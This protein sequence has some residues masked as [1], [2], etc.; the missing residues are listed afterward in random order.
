M[1]RDIFLL[2]WIFHGNFAKHF[3]FSPKRKLK[4][5][6]NNSSQQWKND[7]AK[8]IHKISRHQF[9]WWYFNVDKATENSVNLTS[10][11]IC[12]DV[13]GILRKVFFYLVVSFF[14]CFSNRFLDSTLNFE[15]EKVLRVEKL[16]SFK[17]FGKFLDELLNRLKLNFIFSICKH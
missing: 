1:I 4:K 9:A 5:Q 7:P 12:F 6:R 17:F 13:D 10:N 3:W 2:M 14:I 11:F 8:F 16:W 15:D